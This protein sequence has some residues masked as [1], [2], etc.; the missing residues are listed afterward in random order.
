MTE[1]LDAAAQG[2]RI[3]LFLDMFA[4][5]ALILMLWAWATHR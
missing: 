5:P 2:N 3:F 4:I 1:L